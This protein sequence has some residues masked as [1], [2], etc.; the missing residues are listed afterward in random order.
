IVRRDFLPCGQDIVTRRPLVLQLVHT[1]AGDGGEWGKFL[2]LD[3]RFVDFNEMRREIEQKTFRLPIYL[4][5]CSLN[6]LDLAL[7][8]LPGLTKVCSSCCC[9]S[10]LRFYCKDSSR[11]LAE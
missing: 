6:V 2:H 11:R 3:K 1:P 7:V 9:C 10:H 4:K 5:I 8:D